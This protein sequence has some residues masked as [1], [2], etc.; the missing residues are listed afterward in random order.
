MPG[1]PRPV[2][3]VVTPAGSHDMTDLTTVKG[4]LN[5]TTTDAA[6]DA[7]L[8]RYITTA[9]K[10]AEQF[11]NRVFVI[12]TVLDSFYPQRDRWPRIVCAGPDPLQLSRFPI[13][14]SSIASV[15]E[16]GVTLT[17]NTDFVADY[18]VGQLIRLDTNG[19]PTS[20][21]TYPITVQY[22][23]GY[24]PLPADVSDAVIRMVAQRW[25]A[26]GRDPNLRGETIPGVYQANY[27]VQTSTSQGQDGN[28][29]PD[30]Q[31]M[32]DNYRVPVVQ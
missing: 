28:M 27:W 19:F 18:A 26:R 17:E 25:F 6:R 22:G 15:I 1:Y 7:V 3:T 9:S 24:S 20:W 16:N 10:A 11:C 30:V 12:E 8:S 4:E 21:M 5:I 31:A 29:S 2:S 13:V 14:A 23:A 32:L